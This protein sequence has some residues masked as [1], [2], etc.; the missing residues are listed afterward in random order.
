ML[1]I[2]WLGTVSFYKENQ[3]NIVKGSH[4]LENFDPHLHC[5]TCVTNFLE[6]GQYQL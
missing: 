2:N 1:T 6:E 3:I 5:W 4:L